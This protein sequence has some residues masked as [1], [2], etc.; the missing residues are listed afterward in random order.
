MYRNNRSQ[1]T[2]WLEDAYA[3]LAS[4]IRQQEDEDDHGLGTDRAREL[5]HTEDLI[6]A[7][8][9][10]AVER[11]LDRGYLYTVDGELFITEPDREA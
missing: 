1:L 3:T 8:A 10:Y 6:E 9:Q 7:D 11:L 5:L 4:E 2:P